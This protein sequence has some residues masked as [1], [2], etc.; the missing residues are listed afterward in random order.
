MIDG[1]LE[2]A[3]SELAR[4]IHC[5]RVQK[6]EDRRRLQEEK[7]KMQTKD[8]CR[9]QEESIERAL[10]RSLCRRQKEAKESVVIWTPNYCNSDAALSRRDANRS[11]RTIRKGNRIERYRISRSAQSGDANIFENA[12][13]F[14]LMS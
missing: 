7:M 3:K 4:R 1:A 8:A 11:C 10:E 13:S 12:I 9:G 14:H 2:K 5:N 6:L